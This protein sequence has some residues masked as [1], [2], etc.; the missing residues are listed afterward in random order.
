MSNN[1]I[2]EPRP[3]RLSGSQPF[4]QQ[5][6]VFIM[7]GERTNVAGSPKFA[8]LIKAGKYEEAVR[9][10]R[11][12]VENGANVIDICMDEGMIDGVSAMTRFLH[13]LASEPEVAKV[14]FMVDSSKWEVIEAGLKSMQGKGIVNSISLKEGEEIFRKHA[15]TVLRYGA[16]AVVMAFDEKGQAATFEDKI[17]I[18]ERA[19]RLLVDDIGF[20]PEDIIFDPNILTVATGMEEHNNYAVDFIQATRWIKANLPHAKVSGGVSN[21][22]FSFRGNDKVREAMHSS[23]L[24][25]AISAGLDMGIVN[26]GML[27]VYEEIE[28]ELKVLVE[29][30]LLNR[31]PDATE[32][33]VDF[34]EQLKAAGSGSTAAEKKTE[35]WRNGT[36]EERISHALVKGI[37]TYIDLDTEEARVKLGR[38]LQVIEGPLMDG[39]GIVGDLFGAGKM[40]LPQVVKSARVMKKAVAYLTPFMEAEKEALAAA[41]QE[42]KAQ[43]K[44]LLATVKGDVHDIG[45]NIVGVVLACNNYE[46]IDMG[47]MVPAERILERAKAEKADIIGLSGLITPSLDEMVHVAREM[48]R[49]GFKL[50]LLIGGATTTRAHTAI[51]IA[52][53]YS[54]PVV[55]V[56]DASRAVPV[57]SNLL[58]D[59]S[60]DAFIE[61]HRSEYE[62]VRKSHAAPRQSVV[63]IAEARARRTPIEWRAEDI[64]QPEFTGVRV[65]GDFPLATLRSF[66]DWS[67]FFHA[68]GLKG[69]Y[70]RILDDE[71]QGAQARQLFAEA[72]ALLDRIIAQKLITARGIYGLFPAYATGDDVELYTD[73]T[74]S[75]VLERFHFLRQQANREGSE[76]C[77][78]LADFIAPRDTNLPDHIGAFAVTSG[79]GLREL[80][81]RFRAEHDDYNA[82]MAEALA[83]RLAEAFA[84][85]LHKR[86]RDEWGYGRLETFTNAELIQEKYRGIRPAPGYP[87]SPD[88]TEKGTIWKLLDVQARTGIQITESFA[89]WP[90][91]SVSGI[92]FAHPESRYFSVGK[93]DRDQVIDYQ[94]RKGMTLP[95]VERW[96]G[97]NLNFDP[98]D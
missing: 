20:A 68:W 70:P 94:K 55:H 89:M 74:R 79:I 21:I 76:P 50:P 56:V 41:G 90:G 65:L 31:R 36:V 82:I 25:H 53:Q 34:G 42:V 60:R 80:C 86:V 26:A 13:L 19:Y 32:R 14:P 16:A 6:G 93:I 35:E 7:I 91:S 28:P 96:L 52:P 77:R 2:I 63:S 45:K 81:D 8:K 98:T 29:D 40:F 83:D 48:E 5:Q 64:P 73:E 12:Q 1:T 72:E 39:M 61:K 49:Q 57:T 22:S 43:G 62:A 11:Q 10:A 97:P 23:F 33:L 47:V 66:I 24:Y 27:E 51:K 95:E 85:C 67:P 18:C 92:Y 54:E 30:V 38:P 17:R 78:C 46:V 59:T 69:V 9:I 3:L 15:T 75:T 37:D 4:T 44:I 71:R 84:E 58:S 88:H 87:A